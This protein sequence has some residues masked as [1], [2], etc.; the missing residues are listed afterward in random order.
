M[1]G[2]HSP[3]GVLA[4][5]APGAELLVACR[6]QWKRAQAVEEIA[7]AARAYCDH[8]EIV[9]DV[10]AAVRRAIE[11]AAEDCLVLV[12]GSFYTVGE[13]YPS[14]LIAWWTALDHKEE[15]HENT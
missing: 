4:A 5:L 3:D 12:S 11:G 2:G 6:P 15:Q 14:D 1:V 9:P 13:V 7:D 10:A 8:V